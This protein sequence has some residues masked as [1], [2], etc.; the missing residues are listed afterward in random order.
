MGEKPALL[1]ALGGI[2]PIDAA[3][4]ERITPVTTAA[5]FVDDVWTNAAVMVELSAADLDGSGVAS[6]KYRLGGGAD[7]MYD[8]PFPVGHGI[9]TLEYWSVDV[10]GNGLDARYRGG[11]VQHDAGLRAELP[12]LLSRVGARAL[13]DA[14]CGDFNWMRH[15]DL[16]SVSYT[17]VD[18]VAPLIERCQRTYGG[19]TRQFVVRDILADPLPRAES[20]EHCQQ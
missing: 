12:R 13:L 15:V 10:A 18:V 9:H 16:G 6:T 1:R 19:A 11:W 4:A 7:T 5:G 2:S 8:G 20:V 14:P 3:S 17:G